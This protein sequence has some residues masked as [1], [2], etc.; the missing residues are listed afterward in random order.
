MRCRPERRLNLEARRLAALAISGLVVFV[1]WASPAMAQARVLGWTE[2]V[3]LPEIGV[4]LVAK[5]DTGADHSSVDARKIR[6][7]RRDG[8][9]WRKRACASPWLARS[10]PQLCSSATAPS[11]SMAIKIAFTQLCLQ[12]D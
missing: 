1:G 3:L 12:I 2:P 11:Q 8:R 9:G 5:L 10:A 7:F 6:L 4:A